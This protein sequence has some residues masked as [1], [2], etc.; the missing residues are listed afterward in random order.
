MVDPIQYQMTFQDGA[1]ILESVAHTSNPLRLCTCDRCG[2][3]IYKHAVAP[4][5]GDYNQINP[6]VVEELTD[7]QFFLCD[8]VADAFLFKLREWSMSQNAI[9]N[10]TQPPNS[11]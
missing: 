8:K 5:F 6:R 3:L 1:D 9:P 4:R 7:H 10:S 11:V 2:D